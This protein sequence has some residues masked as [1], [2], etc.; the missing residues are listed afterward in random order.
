MSKRPL[1]ASTLSRRTLSAPYIS[2]AGCSIKSFSGTVKWRIHILFVL[3]EG[4]PLNLPKKPS[5]S[6]LGD[7]YRACASKYM[8]YFAAPGLKKALVDYSSYT[9]YRATEVWSAGLL[10]AQFKKLWAYSQAG[11]GAFCEPTSRSDAA[12]LA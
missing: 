3:L 9:L 4:D 2:L 7:Q 5:S 8:D 6:F 10:Q 1:R 12:P 11:S